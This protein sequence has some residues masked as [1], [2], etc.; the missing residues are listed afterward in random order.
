MLD[1]MLPARLIRAL[2]SFRSWKAEVMALDET[3]KS[4]SGSLVAVKPIYGWGWSRRDAP[5]IP[6]PAE[7]NGVPHP[8]H[9]RIKG[10]FYFQCKL[11]GAVGTIEESEHIY[12]GLWVVFYTRTVG[13]YDF[14]NSLPHCDIQIGS[15]IPVGEWPEFTSGSLIVNG[16][17]FVGESLRHIEE[18]DARMIAQS[19]G[20]V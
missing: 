16:Y 6:V 2:D 8:F 20:A 17:C 7:I 11:R 4:Y 15:V 9:C 3:C 13:T 5:E 1:T 18:N 12:D 19:K 10:F 14:T